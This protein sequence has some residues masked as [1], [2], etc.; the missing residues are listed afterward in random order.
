MNLERRCDKGCSQGSNSG[1]FFWN[2]VAKFL[3]E[4]DL[5]EF[6]KFVAYEIDFTLLIEAP[7]AY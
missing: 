7:N 3:V 5:G 6:G 2:V 4:L 1:A